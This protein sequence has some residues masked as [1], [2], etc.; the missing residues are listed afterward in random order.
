MRQSHKHTTLRIL[1]K[2]GILTPSYLLK[3]L[4]IAGMAGNTTIGFGSRQDVLFAVDKKH[5]V[6]TTNQLEKQG[7]EYMVSS[8]QTAR[9]QNIVSS[10][11]SAGLQNATQWLTPGN[12][13]HILAQFS[14]PHLLRINLADACQSMVP[15][16][17]GHL[18]FVAS[19]QKHYWY[20]YLQLPNMDVRFMWPMLV[21]ST[22]IPALS[23]A[24]E[25]LWAQKNNIQPD[26]LVQELLS[27]TALNHKKMD[28]PLQYTQAFSPDYEG[29]GRMYE[30]PDYWLGLYWR[31][32][33]YD[34]LFLEDVC[35]MAI[36]CGIANVAITPW[37]SI[38]VKGIPESEKVNWL[39]LLGRYGITTQHS[40]FDLNWHLPYGNASALKLKQYIVKQFDKH[41][42]CVQGLTFGFAN[43]SDIPFFSVMIKEVFPKQWMKHLGIARSYT[44]LVSKGYDPNSGVYNVFEANCSKK[45]LPEVLSRATQTY[46]KQFIS[47]YAPSLAMDEV[48]I[49]KV[50]AH[51]CPHCQT[52][53]LPQYGDAALSIAPGTP[54]EKLPDDYC[55]PTCETEKR[56]FTLIDLAKHKIA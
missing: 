3:I 55:C 21:Y 41:D 4:R 36:K 11:A 54:F 37:K 24:I 20:L 12:Y 47:R 10:F 15:L 40:A 22:D 43:E 19:P 31:N 17:F 35:R 45:M 27:T 39:S 53:Y 7:I 56:H 29:F 13:T 48:R 49:D 32:N 1:V 28:A 16:F 5:V 38:V 30:S 8:S 25:E 46:Y 18:N 42:V 14:H 23:K 33:H 34:I 52:V 44:I 51:Q 50:I 6:P 2:G 26:E 9:R